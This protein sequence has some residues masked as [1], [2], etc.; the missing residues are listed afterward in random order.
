M[1]I[2]TDRLIIRRMRDGDLEDFLD[3][4]SHPDHTR[5]LSR[6]SYTE[7]QAR[8]FIAVAQDLSIG[9]EG[10]YL[11]LAVE[12]QSTAK[13]IGTVCVKVASQ[14]HR[15]GDVGWFLHAD[16]QGQGLAT[17]ASR[18]MLEFAFTTLNLHRVTAHCDAQNTR[19]RLMM[20]RLGMR[21]EAYYRGIAYFD[22]VWHDQYLYAMLAAEWAG[23][24]TVKE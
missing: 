16:Y 13:M 4:E 14:A 5:Y 2:E 23:V 22:E 18:A 17:E 8:D 12:L 1:Q 15:Q 6:E 11:H 24:G 9:A 21:R 19:S 7:D 3:Y 10:Q 20:E